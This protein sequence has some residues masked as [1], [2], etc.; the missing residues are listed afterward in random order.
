[1]K[2]LGTSLRFLG[3]RQ[4]TQELIGRLRRYKFPS[5]RIEKVPLSELVQSN[6]IPVAASGN[7]KVEDLMEMYE[8]EDLPSSR[9]KK[10]DEFMGN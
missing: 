10:W 3:S 7:F 6:R 1:M 9:R 5:G 4:G 8:E 2:L